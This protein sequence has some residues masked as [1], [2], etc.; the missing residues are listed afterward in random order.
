MK[1]FKKGWLNREY[2]IFILLFVLIKFSLNSVYAQ[3]KLSEQ[4]RQLVTANSGVVYGSV[5]D[6]KGQTL[7]YATITILNIKDSSLVSGGITN[8]KGTCIIHPIPWG[9]YIAKISFI[10]YKNIITS[11]FSITKSSPTYNLQKQKMNLSQNIIEGVTIKAEKEMLQNNLDKKVFN[12]DKSIAADGVTALEVLENIP[13]VNVDIEGNISLRGSS[14]LTILID[15]RPTN[16]TMDQIPSSMI[17]SV[18]LITNPSA[19]YEPDGISGIINVVLKKKKES[20]FNGMI[21]AGSSISNLDSNFYLKRSNLSTNINYRYNKINIFANYDLRDNNFHS[22]NTLNRTSVFNN[23][24]TTLEQLS[25]SV[26]K[27]NSHNLRTGI[28]YFINKK[29]TL[30]FNISYSKFKRG[31]MSNSASKSTTNATDTFDKE[32]MLNNQ[33]NNANQNISSNLF[34]KY[35][36][37]KPG[38]ELT[39][40]LYYTRMWGNNDLF[41][42]EKYSIPVNRDNYYNNSITKG[43]NQFITSQVDFVTP[44]GN[45]GRIETGYKFSLRNTIQEYHQYTGNDTN[46]LTEAISYANNYNY[47]EYINAAYFI[48]SN[49]IKEKFKY[50]IGLRGELANN[51]FHPLNAD[52]NTRSFYPNL[53]PTVHLVYDFNKHNSISLSYSM[54]VRRPNIFQLNPYLNDADRFNLSVGNPNLK[55]ELTNSVELGYQYYNDKVS[56]NTSIFYRHRYQMISRYTELLNDSVSLTSF[57]NFDQAQS[58]GIEAYYNHTLFK[59]WKINING[60]F[61]QTLIDSRQEMI[62]PNLLNDWS[63]NI[64][65]VLIFSL[66]KDFDIQLTSSYR[67]PMITT[68]SMGGFGWGGGSGQ[69]RISQQWSMDIGFKK[70]FLKKNMTLSI[71]INDIFATRKSNIYTFG[72]S[73]ISSFDAYSFR[74]NDSRQLAISLSYKINNYRPKKYTHG[75][76]FDEQYEE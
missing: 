29:N 24:T 7:E 25:N 36:F 35:N 68:G 31:N 76:E 34:Y 66:P 56:V 37:N 46:S 52:T 59:W 58:Y 22:I 1:T 43:N 11:S 26:S 14:S 4:A 74:K 48:Y 17:E 55:P 42:N 9:T 45:G 47:D 67:S 72:S 73:D 30:S 16:L 44:V 2:R 5:V 23:D 69:G 63:W 18:E 10:G 54:R 75:G 40:D 21:S 32:Y 13:S 41:S 65:G 6:E 3:G 53:F 27:G 28:D 57:Q 49:T 39:V 70:L 61:Y 33:R 50:Q 38:S 12:I 51:V 60:T 71:R 8:E 15:G 19:R 64:R 20:G 62:D